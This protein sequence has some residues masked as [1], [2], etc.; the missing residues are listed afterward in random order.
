MTFQLDIK[1]A[2]GLVNEAEMLVARYPRLAPDELDRLV[3]IYPL[4]PSVDVALMISD[5]DLGPKL[6]S[7]TGAER[8]RLRTPPLHLFALLIPRLF[9]VL[10]FLVVL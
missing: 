7:F 5:P 10:V 8:R 1:R 2:A 3:E 6:E 4:L 9:L